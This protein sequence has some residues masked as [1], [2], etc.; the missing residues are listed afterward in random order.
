MLGPNGKKLH[1]NIREPS[2]KDDCG[3]ENIRV[4][5]RS[6][7]ERSGVLHY[8][9]NVE[10]SVIL[11]EIFHLLGLP[12]EYSLGNP[13]RVDVPESIMSQDHIRWHSVFNSKTR[14][15]LLD[16]AHFNSILHKNC[17]A[18][19]RL[20]DECLRRSED[21]SKNECVEKKRQC[22]SKN[23]VGRNKQK[24]IEIIKEQIKEV[25]KNVSPKNKEGRKNIEK[26]IE[27]LS[28]GEHGEEAVDFWKKQ[29]RQLDQ[30]ES[31]SY[32]HII[33]LEERLKMVESW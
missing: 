6:P 4:A 32:K 8:S 9:S 17:M 3:V 5:I 29:L 20:Y 12:D 22:E 10:C 13:C 7:N 16:P 26:I 21:W 31:D 33:K 27:E 24:E 19:N 15:S 23:L 30:L 28:T 1:I 14:D 18:K 2:K 11:H 25:R